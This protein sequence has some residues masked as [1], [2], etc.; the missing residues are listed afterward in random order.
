MATKSD[1]CIHPPLCGCVSTMCFTTEHQ[2]LGCHVGPTYRRY[3]V[4]FNYHGKRLSG[5][6]LFGRLPAPLQASSSTWIALQ[7]C[8]VADFAA[9]RCRL[10]PARPIDRCD[11]VYAPC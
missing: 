9:V 2:R 1:A 11:R 6:A 4:S 3:L 5:S 7:H 8:A 10:L